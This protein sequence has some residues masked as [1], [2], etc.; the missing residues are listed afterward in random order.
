MATLQELDQIHELLQKEL[1]FIGKEEFKGHCNTCSEPIFGKVTSYTQQEFKNNFHPECFVCGNC[2]QSMEGKAF[3]NHDGKM[4]DMECYHKVVLGS[5]DACHLQFSDPTVIKANG[6][7][8][9]P[10]CFKCS[11]CTNLLASSY[12]DKDS[13]FFCKV[14][15]LFNSR[16]VMKNNSF[17]LAELASC[18][19]HRKSNNEFYNSGSNKLMAIEWKDKK[20]H[21]S[22]FACKSCKVSPDLTL[23]TIYRVKGCYS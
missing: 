21:V 16:L 7:K 1:Q 9:H 23:E 4:L 3:Y 20:F 14:Y 6:K 17:R 8:F 2:S 15:L 19:S 11:S 22:C 13:K 12:I 18:Q 10:D 5:C